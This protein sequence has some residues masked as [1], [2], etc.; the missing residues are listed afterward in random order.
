MRLVDAANRAGGKDNIS[1]VFVAGPEFTTSRA[2]HSIT[3]VRRY[4]RWRSVVSRLLWLA[5][6]VILGI[7]LW[8]AVSRFLPHRSPPIRLSS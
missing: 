3:R 8:N 6:G 5:M 2:R 1:V 7:A 4:P